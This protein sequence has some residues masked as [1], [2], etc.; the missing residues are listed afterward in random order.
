M[1]RVGTRA[2]PAQARVAGGAAFRIPRDRSRCPQPPMAI[3]VCPD[4]VSLSARV[5]LEER[6][7]GSAVSRW[8][9]MERWRL[10]ARRWVRAEGR[11][12][13]WRERPLPPS[14]GGT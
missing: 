4:A 9:S 6:L 14:I 8:P 1:T 12:V 11:R 13:E 5:P 7:Q 10:H 2:V 3:A